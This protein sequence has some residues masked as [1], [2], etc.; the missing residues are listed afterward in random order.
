VHLHPTWQTRI[1]E[2]FT[3]FF[4]QIQFIVT[5]HSPLVCRACENG[6]I[7]RLTS[8]GSNIQS[9]EIKGTDRERLIFGDILDAYGTDI[10]GKTAAKAAKT[11]EKKDELGKLNMMAAFGKITEK[12]EKIRQE[13]LKVLSTQ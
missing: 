8:P 11:D 2:W 13:L 9:G 1:G 10:F 12:D 6:S 3:H 7:W 5:T 4:P